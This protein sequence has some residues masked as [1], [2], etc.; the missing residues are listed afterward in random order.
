LEEL[1]VYFQKEKISLNFPHLKYLEGCP[2]HI[3][4][5]NCPNL[6]VFSVQNTGDYGT[7]KEIDIPNTLILNLEEPMQ[8]FLDIFDRI[9]GDP[10]FFT[11][12]LIFLSKYKDN[13]F[14][15][16]RFLIF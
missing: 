3:Q 11:Q 14:H 15:H 7:K 6:E 13:K 9:A 8:T 5:E 4:V 2:H 10:L 1:H 12:Y 16:S